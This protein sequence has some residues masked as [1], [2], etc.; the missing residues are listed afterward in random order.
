MTMMGTGQRREI[1]R[2]ERKIRDLEAY[3][4]SLLARVLDRDPEL[5]E[6]PRNSA[7][8]RDCPSPLP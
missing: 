4:D 8:H 1:A 6:S 5:L 7:G 3:I 2:R